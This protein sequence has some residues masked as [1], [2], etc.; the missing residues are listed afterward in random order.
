MGSG[1][2]HVRVPA[3]IDVSGAV[4]TPYEPTSVTFLVSGKVIRA[5]IPAR[6][7]LGNPGDH[8]FAADPR[9][10]DC[11]HGNPCDRRRDAGGPDAIVIAGVGRCN[12]FEPQVKWL[13]D[14]ESN[15]FLNHPIMAQANLG[16]TLAVRLC[17]DGGF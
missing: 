12:G 15:R 16:R 8:H 7:R 3:E 2:A 6:H 4:E 9:G 14:G 11:R 1:C 10:S 17:K 13:F 5:R